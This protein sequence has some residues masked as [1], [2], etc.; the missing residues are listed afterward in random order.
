ML[1]TASQYHGGLR[2]GGQPAQKPCSHPATLRGLHRA[3]PVFG[4]PAYVC[5][6]PW[7]LGTLRICMALVFGYCACAHTGTT[8]TAHT[9]CCEAHHFPRAQPPQ[10][11]CAQVSKQRALPADPGTAP[12]SAP[13]ASRRPPASPQ[14]PR[15]PQAPAP[16][17]P[18]PRRRRAA[19][20]GAE[21]GQGPARPVPLPPLPGGRRPRGGARGPRAMGGGRRGAG[22]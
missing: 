16:P 8:Y 5:V 22:R 18:P 17:Q 7:H 12:V 9:L 15:S 19:R 21:G 6:W 20:G 2:P 10:N 13:P 3:R 14:A 1:P 11:L 4:Y